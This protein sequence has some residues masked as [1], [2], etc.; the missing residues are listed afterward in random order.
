MLPVP[1]TGAGTDGQRLT[2]AAGRALSLGSCDHLWPTRTLTWAD[3]RG[4]ASPSSATFT[5]VPRC[6]PSNLVRLWCGS[7]AMH[8]GSRSLSGESRPAA[9]TDLPNPGMDRRT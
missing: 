3:A 9:S 2:T 4:A 8:G 6:S 5:V 1:S 7:D